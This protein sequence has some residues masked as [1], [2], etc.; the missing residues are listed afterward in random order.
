M[1]SLHYVL[2]ENKNPVV[3][4]LYRWAEWFED[5]NNRRVAHDTV[6][7]VRVST[8]FLGLDH[9]FGLSEKPILFET[10]VFGGKHNDLQWRYATWQEA[11]EG[12]KEALALVEG[13]R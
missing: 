2:D 4:S 1:S 13:V 8:V 3:A 12:H 6:D 9:G 10:M 7:D 11:V 5:I